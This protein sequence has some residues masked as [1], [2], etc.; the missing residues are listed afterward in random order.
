[1]R[2]VFIIIMCAVC[3]I[4][5]AKFLT[6]ERQDRSEDVLAG[7]IKVPQVSLLQS[8]SMTKIESKAHKGY[9]TVFF[10]F[11]ENCHYCE[12]ETQSIVQN[13]AKLKKVKFYFLSINSISRIERFKERY[14]LDQYSNIL[15]G[16]DHEYSI[17][18]LFKINGIP[19]MVVYDEKGRLMK[20]F[21]GGTKA[22]ELISLLKL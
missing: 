19:A 1:M 21:E 17:L 2:R 14:H 10:F 9:A 11:D 5:A 8:D 15:V 22:P 12:E 4:A 7:I 3:F 20:I 13:D 6:Q 18:K 16:K